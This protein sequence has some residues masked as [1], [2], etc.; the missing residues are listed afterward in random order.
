MA[1]SAAGLH[2]DSPPQDD[3]QYWT[4]QLIAILRASLIKAYPPGTRTLRDAHSKAHG[5]LRAEFIVN[6]NVPPE[7]RIG[8]F[9]VPRSY[10][11]WIRFSSSANSVRPDTKRDVLGMAIKLLDVSH[12]FLDIC[13]A[14]CS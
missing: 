12:Q 8:V 14:S 2:P 9:A 13:H 4:D 10:D 11:A 7:L 1:D 3:E 6:D 5:C